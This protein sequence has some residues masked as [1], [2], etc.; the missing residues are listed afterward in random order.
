[1]YIY[2]DV[3]GRARM[4]AAWWD[5]GRLHGHPWDIVSLHWMLGIQKWRLAG[6]HQL[7]AACGRRR[8]KW[9]S[10]PI[11]VSHY[12][13]R[14]V[15]GAVAGAQWLSAG[16]T[17][18]WARP[19]ASPLAIGRQLGGHC[20]WV[21]ALWG[22][23]AA[24]HYLTIALDVIPISNRWGYVML[25]MLCVGAEAC[26]G[27]MRWCS[28][29]ASRLS[30]IRALCCSLEH[31]MKRPHTQQQKWIQFRLQ[32]IETMRTYC[33]CTYDGAIVLPAMECVLCVHT[34]KPWC[35]NLPS[36]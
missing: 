16:C 1:M 33:K 26:G 27:A 6:L 10:G 3:S 12:S 35:S 32:D 30:H 20:V 31:A 18:L 2:S 8:G 19:V 34:A 29:T 15:W 14:T 9:I 24:Q 21:A 36:F 22:T 7:P 5:R 28:H 25:Y 23:M 17:C 13:T 11:A 4:K